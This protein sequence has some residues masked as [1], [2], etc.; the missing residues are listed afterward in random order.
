MPNSFIK[1]LARKT[2]KSVSEIED[3]WKDAEAI[4]RSTGINREDVS[5]YPQVT[6]ITKKLVKEVSKKE[7]HIHIRYGDIPNREISN[8]FK[9][10]KFKRDQRRR[11]R[12]KESNVVPKRS[13]KREDISLTYSILAELYNEDTN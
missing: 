2:G 13:T 9:P 10:D 8:I 4:V 7:G 12:D 6:S 3:A 1:S 5:Y 11:D